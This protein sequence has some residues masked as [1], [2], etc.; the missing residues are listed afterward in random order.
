MKQYCF[1]RGKRASVVIVFV[2]VLSCF[3]STKGDLDTPGDGVLVGNIDVYNI[4]VA[5]NNS[6]VPEKHETSSLKEEHRNDSSSRAEELF[7]KAM[8]TRLKQHASKEELRLS[9]HQLYAAAGIV[10]LSMNHSSASGHEMNGSLYYT[11][12]DVQ[13]DWRN[14]TIQH[15]DAVRELIYAFRDGTTWC[16]F[17]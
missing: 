11:A 13:V 12:D 1:I 9:I 4:S 15:I 3:H 8:A 5:G 2:L 17:V 14:G 6:T 10:H 16:V 7:K